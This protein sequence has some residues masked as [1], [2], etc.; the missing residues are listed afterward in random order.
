MA[1]V[2]IASIPLRSSA[3]PR[4]PMKAWKYLV[5]PGDGAAAFLFTLFRKKCGDAPY[6]Q[7]GPPALLLGPNAA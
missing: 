1:D 7:N 5:V 4:T 2:P 3:P 6:V